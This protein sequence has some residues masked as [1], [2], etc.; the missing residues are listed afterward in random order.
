M[1]KIDQIKKNQRGADE[2]TLPIKA[3]STVDEVQDAQGKPDKDV[4]IGEKRI[5]WSQL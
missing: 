4:V 1:L 2:T 5:L 3:G